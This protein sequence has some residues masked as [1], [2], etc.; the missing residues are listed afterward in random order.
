MHFDTNETSDSDTTDDDKVSTESSFLEKQDIKPFWTNKCLDVSKNIWLPNNDNSVIVKTKT[1]SWFKVETVMNKS[2]T[3]N[4][5][6]VPLQITENT[7]KK[8]RTRKIRLYPTQTQAKIL[9]QWNGTTRYIYN[10][11]NEYIKREQVEQNDIK[12]YGKHGLI[13]FFY[14]RN[15]FVTNKNI[16]K[17]LQWQTETPKDV[18]AGAVN[19]LVKAYNTSFSLLKNKKIKKFDVGFRR[20]K[21]CVF[22][23]VIA[24]SAVP[25][26]EYNFHAENG[27]LLCHVKEKSIPKCLRMNFAPWIRV[28]ENSKHCMLRIRW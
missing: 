14:L 20:K 2:F 8:L 27:T 25:T 24:K 18:R 13:N 7:E 16:P 4:E 26:A 15:T 22:S 17:E 11:A 10:K 12:K 6:I 19:D 23:L 5:F 3:R 21:D 28:I 9:R 1:D